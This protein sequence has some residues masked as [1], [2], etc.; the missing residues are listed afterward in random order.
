MGSRVTVQQGVMDITVSLT[1]MDCPS[2]AV[3]YAIPDRME[4]E[5]REDGKGFYC[6]N[7]HSLTFDGEIHK[8]RKR[9]A[10]VEKDV[11]WYKDAEKSEREQRQ[12]AERS[13]TATKGVV[14]KMRKRA[15]AGVCQ[16]CHRHFT[17]MERH[18]ASKHQGTEAEDA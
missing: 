16:F 7:G 17:D 10:S 6:P 1:V 15:I 4:R 11:Q 8:L 13:L 3:I 18:V 9:L 14:T 5:R 12:Q 2:C